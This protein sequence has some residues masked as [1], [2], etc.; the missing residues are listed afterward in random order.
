MLVGVGVGRRS[1]GVVLDE[2]T[3]VRRN[4]VE[5][6]RLVMSIPT[7]RATLYSEPK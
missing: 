7:S 5:S 2:R 1:R 4:G 6:G 3:E